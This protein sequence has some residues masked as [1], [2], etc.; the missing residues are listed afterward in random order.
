MKKTL[1]F[2]ALLSGTVAA[3]AW[4]QQA[5]TVIVSG[6]PA[7]PQLLQL[8]YNVKDALVNSEAE[9]TAST[10]AQ[11]AQAVNAINVSSLNASEQKSFT[12]VKTGIL[13]EAG[14]IAATRNL[15]QQRDY[16]KTLSESFYQLIDKADQA[17]ITAYRQY[18]P[19]QKAYWLSNEQAIKN[20]YYGKQMLNCG[21][22]TETIK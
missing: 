5:K 11:L 1:L 2:A 15:K 19:M 9:L 18:C 4:Q 12:I 21:K 16:F 7:I 10:A 13:K 6:K 14:Q 3:N 20:P 22:V 17:G 8:Y